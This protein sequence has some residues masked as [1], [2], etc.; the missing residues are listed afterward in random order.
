M[1]RNFRLNRQN[2]FTYHRRFRRM[3]QKSTK[4]VAFISLTACSCSPPRVQQ[5]HQ[6]AEELQALA[7]YD[8]VRWHR[9]APFG[10]QHLCSIIHMLRGQD[11]SDDSEE[12]SMTAW[13]VRREGFASYAQLDQTA[14]YPIIITR[15]YNTNQ[16]RVAILWSQ[17]PCFSQSTSSDSTSECFLLLRGRGDA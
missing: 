17:G 13:S 6:V 4:M 14:Q 15:K 1:F 10:L 8:Q 3:R 9:G 2:L 7:E 11:H 16:I 12:R 5:E